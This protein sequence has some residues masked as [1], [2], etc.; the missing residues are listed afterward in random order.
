[1]MMIH[2]HYIYMCMYILLQYVTVIY[3]YVY[4]VRVGWGKVGGREG[5]I[6]DRVYG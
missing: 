2:K 4:D 1:M 6:Y 3:V 5:V